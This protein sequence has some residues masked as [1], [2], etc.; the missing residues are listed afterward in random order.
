VIAVALTFA[1]FGLFVAGPAAL[2]A[3]SKD[4]ESA[5]L[6]GATITMNAVRVLPSIDVVASRDDPSA[7]GQIRVVQSP[8][9][10]Q[11]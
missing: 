7:A 6:A 3:H 8:R 5:V 2:I 1:T 4:A 10:T 9:K 11:S